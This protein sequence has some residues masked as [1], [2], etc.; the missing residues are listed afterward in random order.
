MTTAEFIVCEVLKCGTYD[1]ETMFGEMDDDLFHNAM[2]ACKDYGEL[3]ANGIWYEAMCIAI[4]QVFGDEYVEDFEI[5]ANA[6]ASS[7]YVLDGANKKIKG[8]K[9]KAAEFEELTGFSIGGW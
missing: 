3:T 8:F 4:S 5:D 2:E 9:A 6:M 1:I 7:V